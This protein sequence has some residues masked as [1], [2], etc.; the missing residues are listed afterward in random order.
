MKIEPL[1]SIIMPVY[2]QPEMVI[3]ALNSIPKR[4]DIEIVIVDDSTDETTENIRR[5]AEGKTSVRLIHHE[6]RM[7]IGHA[8]NEAIENATGRY[9]H[10]LDADDWLYTREYEQAMA[11]L[12]G[13]DIVYISLRINSGAVFW[14]TEESQRGF[15]AGTAR[16]IRREFLGDTRCDEVMCNEDFEFNERLQ[17]KPHT[18]KFTRIVA[19]HYNFPREGSLYDMMIKGQIQP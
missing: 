3:R 8:K 1:V 16:F 13:T 11:A 5:W 6:T 12:D 4:D 2:N 15:C 18:D 19:Y 10:E 9:V 7:G 17:A 14:V